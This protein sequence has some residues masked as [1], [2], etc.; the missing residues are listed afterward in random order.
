MSNMWTE[1]SPDFEEFYHKYMED[2]EKYA[3]NHGIL[4]KPEMPP[5]NSYMIGMLPWIEFTSYAPIPYANTEYYFPIIQAGRFSE[6]DGKK[7]MPLSITVH[8]AVADGYH[9]GLFLDK[10]KMGM[11]NPE[12]WS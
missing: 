2:Q 12:H 4:A 1:Y 6:R 8:H 5:H 10:F 11:A 9:V 7:F 3:D